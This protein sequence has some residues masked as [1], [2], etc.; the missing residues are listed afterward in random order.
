MGFLLRL[1]VR[2][3]RVLRAGV[4]RGLAGQDRG[5]RCLQRARAGLRGLPD[6][7][8]QAALPQRRVQ[9]AVL[10]D[11]AHAG[12][13]FRLLARGGDSQSVRRLL[14]PRAHRGH[15]P[16]LLHRHVPRRARVLHEGG[17]ERA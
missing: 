16:L 13:R 10:P 11:A 3:R 5:R 14:P 1:P 4:P 7:F 8:V 12:D 15:G 2:L 17:A 9:R 6:H